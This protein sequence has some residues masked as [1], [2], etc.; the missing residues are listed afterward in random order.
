MKKKLLLSFFIL[1]VISYAQEEC[2]YRG[3]LLDS[4]QLP[5]FDASITAFDSENNSAG[6]T[7]SDKNGEF[8]LKMKCN[9][10]YEIEVEH[11]EFE[12]KLIKVDLLKSIRE[13]I[14]LTRSVV[15]LEDV[16]AKGR[17][18]IRVKG[19]TIE[20]D[21]DSFTTGEEEDLEDLLKKLPGIEVENGKVYHQGKQ[22]NSI[23]VDGREI[24]GGNTKLLTKNLPS[25]VVDKIQLNKKFKANPFAN[26][27]QDEEQPEL[28]I[29]LKEDKKSLIF[30]NITIG[31]DAHKNYDLQEKLFR[32]SPKTDAT[33]ISDFNTYG[34]EVFDSEDYFH[35]LGG[36]SEFQ[37]E[38]GL[39]ALRNSMSAIN[40]ASGKSASEVQN[41]LGA[42]HFGYEPNS[43][44]HVNGFSLAT[45]N[46]NKFKSSSKRI[47]QDFS[48]KDENN[49]TEEILSI[50]SRIE[51][52]Y[53][54]R[55]NYNI[56]Y[57]VNFNQQNMDNSSDVAS[58]LNDSNDAFSNR[59]SFV[60][61]KN[62]S[63]NQR[64][65]FIK[66][67]GSDDNF[68]LYL[69][70]LYQNETPNLRVSSDKQPFNNL[71]DLVP[72]NGLYKINQNQ[73]L[74]ANT[75]QV[76]SIYNHLI[77]NL[78]N[79]RIKLGVNQSFQKLDNQIIGNQTLLEN[80]EANYLS[81]FK[82]GEY[83]ADAT[84]TR[85]INKFKFDLGAGLHH[86]N[87]TNKNKIKDT[88][89]AITRVL[90][91][92]KMEYNFSTNKA[93]RLNYEHKYE[94]P[95]IR[96]L[97]EAYD[98]KGYY[99]LFV[100]NH[101]LNPSRYHRI[102]LR[103]NFY[104]FYKFMSFWASAS[105]NRKI[106]NIRRAGT[107]D[108]LNQISSPFNNQT[109]ED[110]WQGNIYF[111]KRLTKMYSLK[112]NGI[113]SFSNFI[114]KSNGIES[115]ANSIFNSFTLTNTLKIRKKVE[116]DLG[117]KWN[118]N[119]YEINK[120][121]NNFNNYS[122]F[123]KGAFVL[124]DRFLFETKY[125]Y[126]YQLSNGEEINQNHDLSA[127]LRFKPMKKLYTRFIVG[128][129]LNGNKLVNSG[130]NNFY[131]YISEKEVLGRYFIVNIRYKF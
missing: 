45:H 64:F 69:T 2:N 91:H 1:S 81:D 83:Y 23:K 54:S 122:P 15:Q 103:Y 60:D 30:G 46:R 99:N 61:R 14:I 20:Y 87:T 94:I 11:I 24:F 8:E 113:S 59:N 130:F 123:A 36:M 124:S 101:Q 86:Y 50:I 68:G 104:N 25:D 21:A 63:L 48:H 105:Y 9:Q 56:R 41:H 119:I 98:L 58:F 47:Y 16:V 96:E 34:K 62:S 73:N 52:K 108:N 125:A 39:N 92:L 66:K 82:F 42:L 13:K 115:K 74:K 44:L 40:F 79:I 18:P 97:T 116:V 67:V 95:Q 29:V 32:F 127:T 100:G 118:S 102:N 111:T 3:M 84:Y 109:P 57:R 22:I 78:S 89:I 112:I 43:R 51:M 70:H 37:Q 85:K 114:S 106:D 131:T 117:M 76:L 55:N 6:F 110:N 72:E 31:G 49:N 120:I 12:S 27:L 4:L 93:I 75:F 71:F 53:T 19:D 5:V 126:D 17:V 26:S 28:N 80:N 35:F 65:S 107:L 33:L 38:G 121:K 129:L 128:N 10:K 90:P 88:E 77:T 7:F